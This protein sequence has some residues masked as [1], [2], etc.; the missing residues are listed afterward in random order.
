LGEKAREAYGF[1]DYALCRGK[2]PPHLIIGDGERRVQ[3]PSSVFN[4]SQFSTGSRSPAPLDKKNESLD[5][6]L[7]GSMAISI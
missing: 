7:E 3:V 5:E 1:K 6:N 4:S 2:M